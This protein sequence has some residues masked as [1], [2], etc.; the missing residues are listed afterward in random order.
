MF[1]VR[2]RTYRP[3]AVMGNCSCASATCW[4]S[5]KAE[6]FVVSLRP[7]ST[8]QLYL[9]PLHEIIGPDV[10]HSSK[11]I[12]TW[13]D[14]WD[15]L[16]RTFYRKHFHPDDYGD[17]EKC[18][19]PRELIASHLLDATLAPAA[20]PPAHDTLAEFKARHAEKIRQA[21]EKAG[22]TEEDATICEILVRRRQP[23]AW[24]LHDAARQ[25]LSL[26]HI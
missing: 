12:R 24:A 16:Q 7:N 10:R 22:W 4:S 18:S 15:R 8:R 25:I 21:V 13:E 2:P 26:I 20:A 9:T 6:E 17:V 23:L 5:T 3:R 19:T 11:K 1:C 14:E